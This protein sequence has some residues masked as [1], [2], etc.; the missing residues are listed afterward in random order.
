MT[1]RSSNGSRVSVTGRRGEEGLA[2]SMA[3][4]RAANAATAS[5]GS[6]LVGDILISDTDIKR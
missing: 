6:R 3:Q 5:N 4:H 1:A 2:A